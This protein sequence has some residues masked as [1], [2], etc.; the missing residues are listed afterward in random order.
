M[1]QHICV[2]P[3]TNQLICRPIEKANNDE[4]NYLSATDEPKLCRLD[5]YKDNQENFY[6]KN[7]GLKFFIG[8]VTL[9]NRDNKCFH[10]EDQQTCDMIRNFIAYEGICN[11]KYVLNRLIVKKFLCGPV[12]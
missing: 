2:S 10:G 9:Y 7:Y 8:P 5:N 12:T 1:Y 6:Y 3:I 4:I 11:D